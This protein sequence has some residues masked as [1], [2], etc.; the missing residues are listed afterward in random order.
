MV[1]FLQIYLLRE[2]LRVS[3]KSCRA[4]S[5]SPHLP[6]LFSTV[7]GF[8]SSFLFLF[9]LSPPSGKSER[10]IRKWKR[11]RKR[12]RISN[13]RERIFFFR[14]SFLLRFLVGSKNGVF[15]F[16]ACDDFDQCI[17]ISS[18]LAMCNEDDVPLFVYRSSPKLSKWL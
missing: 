3:R 2:R 10:K 12:R 14:S 5:T 8:P 15:S 11:R 6:L 18:Q 9:F 1:F 4:K 17:G 7:Q 13:S 16:V